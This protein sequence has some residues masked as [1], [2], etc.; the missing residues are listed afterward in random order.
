[1]DLAW[2]TPSP[3]VT[4]PEAAEAIRA[5]YGLAGELARLPGEAD[6]NFALR[7]DGGQRYVVKV[8]H[9]RAD[10]AVVGVQV[11]ACST[12]SRWPPGCPCRGSCPPSAASR[13]PWSR[14]ARCAGASCTS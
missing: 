9:L 12:S 10:P 13:G 14:T 8:A 11:R 2:L 5:C 3:P 4:A 7:P 1:M 6:D